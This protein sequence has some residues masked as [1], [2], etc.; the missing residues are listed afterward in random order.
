MRSD[1]DVQR[2]KDLSVAVHIDTYLQRT[3]SGLILHN[4]MPLFDGGINQ[5]AVKLTLEIVKQPF[6]GCRRRVLRI[7]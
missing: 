3:P 2:L 5:Y 7:E 4:A 1:K 6:C